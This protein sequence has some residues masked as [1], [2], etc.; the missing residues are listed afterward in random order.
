MEGSKVG[1]ASRLKKMRRMQG[2]EFEKDSDKRSVIRQ[3]SWVNVLGGALFILVGIMMIIQGIE[4]YKTGTIIPATIKSGP[5]TGPQSILV[6]SLIAII[7][8]ALW[9]YEILKIIKQK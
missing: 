3:V 7:G 4:A 8:M 5:M 9:G 2:V 6:G 1:R